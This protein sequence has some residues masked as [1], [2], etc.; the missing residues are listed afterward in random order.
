[1]AAELRLIIATAG[2]PELLDR[3]LA[4]FAACDKP[5]NYQG[6]IVAENGPPQGVKEVVESTPES[7]KASYVHVEQANKSNA[8]NVAMEDLPDNCLAI[9]TD[10]DVRAEPNFFESYATSAQGMDSGRFFGGPM[11]AEY[12]LEPLSYVRPYLPGSAVGWSPDPE[13]DPTLQLFLGCNWGAFV[14]DLRRA[15]LFD[16]RLGP[17]GT[18]DAVAQDW[19]MQ[20]DL[21]KIGVHAVI[22]RDALVHHWVPKERC[23]PEWTC[24]R[25]F[26]NGIRR[27]NLLR[28]GRGIPRLKN[29]VRN[30]GPIAS[31]TLGYVATRFCWSPSIRFSS[32]YNLR[33]TQGILRGLAPRRDS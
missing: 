14:G 7:L 23:S 6:V 5:S 24:Q 28:D 27:G 1:M 33:V 21:H 2:R 10:D 15:D 9:F 31:G 22:V 32:E 30:L 13:T 16:V 29:L 3:T 20:Q 4:S 11:T 12:E 18:T 8:L 25:G 19:Q 26:R 17:G